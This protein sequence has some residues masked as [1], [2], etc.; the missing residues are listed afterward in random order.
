MPIQSADS[1]VGTIAPEV[2]NTMRKL[3]RYSP[4]KIELSKMETKKA[5][6]RAALYRAATKA[7]MSLVTSSDQGNPYVYAC[8]GARLDS[9]AG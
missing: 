9:T 3:D 4:I 5:S 2:V 1:S 8:I 7:R 6:L